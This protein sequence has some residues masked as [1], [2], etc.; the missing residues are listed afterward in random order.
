MKRILGGPVPVATPELPPNNSTY[1]QATKWGNLIFVSGQ[2]GIDPDSR[3]LVE[4]GMASQT[5]QALRNVSTILEAAGS[6]LN[7]VARVNIYITRFEAL[8]VVNEVFSQFFG[9]HKPAKTTVE[10]S[11]LDRDALIEIEVIAST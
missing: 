4:G 10:V 1:S 9:D 5:R 2:L 3:R 11:R 8:V 6:S 7:N